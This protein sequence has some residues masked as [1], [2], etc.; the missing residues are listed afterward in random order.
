VTL[1]DKL[2]AGPAENNVARLGKIA[3]LLERQGINLDEIGSVKR[4]SVYQ[5]LTKNEEGEAEVHDLYGIQFSPSWETGPQWPVVQPGPVVKVAKSSVRRIVEIEN[6]RCLILP[7]M[8][9]GYYRDENDNLVA[10][11]DEVAIDLAIRLC[12]DIRPH[13][14]VMHGDNLDLPEMGKYRL[15]PAF[16]RTTQAAIDYATTMVARLRAAAPEAEIYWIAGNHE[17]RLVNYMLDNASAAFGLKRG[18]APASWPVLSVP[19]LCRFDEHDIDYVAGYPA[20]QVWVN[21]KLRIIH[22]SKAK[23]NGSTAH[24]YLQHEKTSVMYGHVHRREWAEQTREDWDGPKTILAA[25]AGCLARTDG[26][27]PSTK[28]GIDLDGRP[29]PVTENWQQGVA[30]V[31]YMDGDAPFHLELVPIHNGSMFYR[32]VLYADNVADLSDL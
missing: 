28:G 11:H 32:G 4:V 23:S 25:S 20:G 14:I 7:D 18:N 5:S 31:T 26:A 21:Q 12:A 1:N 29:L 17:E 2:N 22:G 19:F 13:K 27:V 10:T 24:Q 3:D 30:V 9:I 6:K 16:G 15:S 8:Q